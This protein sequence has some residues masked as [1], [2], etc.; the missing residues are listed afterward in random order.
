MVPT[1][2]VTELVLVTK[3]QIPVGVKEKT[4][5]ALA[6]PPCLLEVVIEVSVAADKSAANA[7]AHR[8]E[9]IRRQGTR[10][11]GQA[12][13]RISRGGL[14]PVRNG[15]RGRQFPTRGVLR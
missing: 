12:R 14:D 9:L 5:G 3:L 13:R 4:V 2:H 15:N 7:G 6:R 10:G 1:Q 8:R 11:A